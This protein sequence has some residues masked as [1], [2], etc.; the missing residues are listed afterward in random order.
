MS[1]PFEFEGWKKFEVE[2]IKKIL[3]PNKQVFLLEIVSF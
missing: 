1:V 3:N 2:I